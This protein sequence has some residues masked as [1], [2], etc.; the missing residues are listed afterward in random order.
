MTE[1]LI[2]E[3]DGDIVTLRLNRPDTRNALSADLVDALE[4]ACR[5][6]NAD[7]SVGCVILTGNGQGFSSGGNVKEMYAGEGMFGGSS[8]EM[9]RGYRGGI[10]RIPVALNDLEPPI[11]AAVN[12]AAIGAGLDLAAM[13]DIRIAA[14]GATFAESF[15]RVGLISGDGGAWFLP[16]VIGFA[17]AME[18]TLTAAAI[19]AAQ[20]AQ[21]GLV[22]RVVAPDALMATAFEIARQIAAHPRHSTRLAKRLLRESQRVD[23]PAALEMAAA[24]QSIVQH[25]HDQKEAVAALVEKRPPRF[26]GR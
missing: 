10:Q 5:R 20:A 21:W 23:L 25:T 22:S 24:M 6:L 18:M 13:C 17:R 11:V 19:D 12:G 9:R 2:E 15:L 26:S 8:A 7:M 1:P 3:R 14:T 4:A 16:R